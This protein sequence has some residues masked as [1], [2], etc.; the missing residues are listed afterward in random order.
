MSGYHKITEH[1]VVQLLVM[2]YS[3][4]PWTAARQASL[5]FTISQ[6]LLI[7][8]PTELVIPSNHLITEH[9]K[10]EKK[11]S[12]FEETKQATE[13]DSYMARMLRIIIQK[14]LNGYEEYANSCRK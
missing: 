5:S 11:K 4:T 9:T 3:A 7:L 8:M 2:S 10:R 12:Q 1:V 6:S 13:P 14:N